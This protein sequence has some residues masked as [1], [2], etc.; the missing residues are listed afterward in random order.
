MVGHASPETG[1]VPAGSSWDPFQ[2]PGATRVI[3]AVSAALAALCLWAFLMSA[4]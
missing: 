4:V 1:K 2:S 3:L